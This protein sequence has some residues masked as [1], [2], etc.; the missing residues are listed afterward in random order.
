VPGRQP[1][2]ESESEPMMARRLAQ[3]RTVDQADE[4]HDSARPADPADAYQA[5]DAMNVHGGYQGARQWQAASQLSPGS[6][7]HTHAAYQA[8][9][10]ASPVHAPL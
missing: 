10:A 1:D 7:N 4:H 9:S 8:A 6:A 3:E 5:E 2:S